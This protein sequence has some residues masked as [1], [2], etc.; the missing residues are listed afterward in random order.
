LFR[1][2]TD[3]IRMCDACQRIEVEQANL[4][5]LMGHHIT[6]RPWTALVADII[7]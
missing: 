5:D 1:D 3:Y 6:D 7:R 4:A 2:V